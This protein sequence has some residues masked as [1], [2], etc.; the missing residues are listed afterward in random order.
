[1][2]GIKHLLENKSLMPFSFELI[3]LSGLKEEV[4]EIRVHPLQNRN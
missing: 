2:Y 3:N 4:L 1:M